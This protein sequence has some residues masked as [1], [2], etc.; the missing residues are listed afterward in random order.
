VARV[1][2]SAPLILFFDR[3]ETAIEVQLRSLSSDPKSVLRS[4]STGVGIGEFAIL[5]DGLSL[6]LRIMSPSL[7]T[8]PHRRIFT[9]YE[10]SS[11]KCVL[12]L[13]FNAH[14]AGGERIP[15]VALAL[16]SVSAT[17]AQSLSAKA[18]LWTPAN[19][20]SETE[21]FAEAVKSYANG[22]AF[23]VLPT[24]DFEF[25]KG[26]S[27]FLS[28]GLAWFSGQELKLESPDM[29]L[30]RMELMKRAVRLAH[31]IAVNG[32]VLKEHVVADLQSH[33]KIVLSL[34]PS[35]TLVTAKITSNVDQSSMAIH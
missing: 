10:T 20:L 21:Y 31:D 19:I 3:D 30:D 14:V 13:S 18:V 33:A 23:P 15:P 25:D 8:I 16:F 4:E 2:N 1:A 22:G 28:S 11:A 7:E 12:E 6:S 5:Y 29:A 26:R 27:T 9:S 32:P 34:D 17:I 35:A 24:I